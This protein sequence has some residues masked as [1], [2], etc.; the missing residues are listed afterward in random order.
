MK[1]S[2]QYLILSF[3]CRVVPDIW[4]ISS[5]FPIPKNNKVGSMNDLRPGALTSVAIQT[6]E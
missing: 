6:C 4:K 5:I 1:Y 3:Q 2:V